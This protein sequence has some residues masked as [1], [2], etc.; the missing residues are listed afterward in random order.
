MWLRELDRVL[1]LVDLCDD[2]LGSIPRGM[3]ADEGGVG[4][5]F[6]EGEVGVEELGHLVRERLDVLDRRLDSEGV[7]DLGETNLDGEWRREGGGEGEE[8]DGV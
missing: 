2:V 8:R 7:T 6:G 3:E 4:G 1:V 5:G